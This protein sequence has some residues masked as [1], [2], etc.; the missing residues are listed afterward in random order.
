MHTNPWLSYPLVPC[1]G[2]R[3]RPTTA[4]WLVALGMTNTSHS[5]SSY[6]RHG[7]VAGSQGTGLVMSLNFH[8]RGNSPCQHSQA[9]KK[10]AE[11]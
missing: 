7:S 9:L 2:T 10:G 3:C 6:L 8:Y 1:S 4:S 11:K 5:S